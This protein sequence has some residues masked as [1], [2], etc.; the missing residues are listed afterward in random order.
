MRKKHL[1]FVAKNLQMTLLLKKENDEE[2]EE[3]LGYINQRNNNAVVHRI[4][5]I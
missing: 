4:L 1:K 2:G 5:L 3:V